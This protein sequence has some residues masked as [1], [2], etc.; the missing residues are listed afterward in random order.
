MFGQGGMSA[1]KVRESGEGTSFKYVRHSGGIVIGEMWET[2]RYMV[3]KNCEPLSA[4]YFHLF[5]DGVLIS[6]EKS[7][8]LDLGPDSEDPDRLSKFLGIQ[9]YFKEEKHE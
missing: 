9:C 4:G 2:H 6:R 8:T 7:L 3:P 5:P 1:E